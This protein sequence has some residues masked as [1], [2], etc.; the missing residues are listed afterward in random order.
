MPSHASLK[1][2]SVAV[3]DSLSVDS[4]SVDTLSADT[5]AKDTK[6]VSK[7]VLDQPVEYVASDSVTFESGVGNANLYGNSKV[8]YTNLE[9]QA[10][11]ITMNMDSSLVHAVGRQDSAGNMKG[12]PVFKQGTDQYEPERISYNFKTR[13][14]FIDNVYTEQ[15]DGF[16]ISEQSKRD[17]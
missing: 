6:K 11:W 4:I 8:N 3:L 14:A 7:S 5:V 15:G 16:L 12:L 10:D 17:A 2:E 9:L 1:W 13:K